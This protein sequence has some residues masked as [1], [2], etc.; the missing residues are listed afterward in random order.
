MIRFF[1]LGFVLFAS[2]V[3]AKAQDIPEQSNPPRLV[4][5]FADILTMDQE[6]TLEQ[7]L[8]QFTRETS[9][10]IAVVI[11]P[12]LNGYDKADFAYQLGEKWGI[13]QK[14]RNNGVLMLI[15]PKYGNERGEAFIATGYGLEGAVPDAMAH[16]IID[17]EMIPRFKQNDYYGGISGGLTVI[18]ELTRGEYTADA[19]IEKNKTSP[20][21]P[22]IVLGIMFLVFFLLSKAN[23]KQPVNINRNGSDLPFWLLMGG[24]AA[25]SKRHNGSWGNFSSG[26]GGFGGGGFGGFGGGSFGG[27]GAGGSW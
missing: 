16:R 24:M 25:S 23:K 13:G 22:L 4:N 21:A 12:S 5:D 27:G 10:Q 26:S 7:Q 1:L 20:F 18:M 19:Y 9:T 2:I 6:M 14:G 17:I 3:T 11:V 15:K 8:V